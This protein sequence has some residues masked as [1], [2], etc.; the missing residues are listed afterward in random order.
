MTERANLLSA[1]VCPFG[2]FQWVRMPFG[3][4]NAPLVYQH[5]INNCPGLKLD[6]YESTDVVLGCT[7]DDPEYPN[8]LTQLPVL[9]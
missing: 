2:H 3:M 9:T 7:C 1:F 8:H 5:M 6:P 4:K